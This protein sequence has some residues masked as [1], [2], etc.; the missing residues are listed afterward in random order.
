V[1]GAPEDMGAA[2]AV[3]PQTV[4]AFMRDSRRAL[5]A[6][7]F[8]VAKGNPNRESDIRAFVIQVH[9]M[10]GALANVGNVELSVEARRL[11]QLGR[12]RN[13]EMILS[14]APAFIKALK[15]FMNEISPEDDSDGS[16]R[17]VSEEDWLMLREDL[18][19]IR[20]ACKDY[21]GYLADATLS[22]LRK[23]A[24]PR[25]QKELLESIS[26]LILH[27]DFEDT[28]SAIDKFLE[29]SE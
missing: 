19:A 20:A 29:K 2:Q 25:K 16:E 12:A 23:T 18:G 13:T 7:E 4:E 5:E 26:E 8:F 10:K 1:D 22:K 15:V 11:E 17:D 9:G 6:L 27:S 21:D 3:D 14:R 28:V 24:W